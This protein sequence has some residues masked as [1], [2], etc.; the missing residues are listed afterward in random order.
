MPKSLRVSRQRL[1]HAPS[2]RVWSVVGDFGHEDHFARNIRHSSRDTSNVGVGTIRTLE[3]A[4]PLMGRDRVEEVIIA[5]EPGRMLAYRLRGSAGPFV[6]AESHW[7][8]REEGRGTIVEVEGRFLPRNVLLGFLIGGA[9]KAMVRRTLDG[10][11][12]E[13]AAYVEGDGIGAVP[14][15][16]SPGS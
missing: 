15:R 10:A 4:K 1:V 14:P 6:S 3:L 9:A 13:L 11:L 7:R 5:I 12:R 16:S 8:L 2:E